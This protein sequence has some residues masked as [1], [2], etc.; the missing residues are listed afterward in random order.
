M[1][2]DS[3]TLLISLSR[4]LRPAISLPS[5]D[6]LEPIS[7]AL[8][9]FADSRHRVGPLLHIAMQNCADI[10]ADS[11]ASP[12]LESAYQK[13]IFASLRQKAAEKK[14]SELLAAHSVPFSFL[15]GRGLAEQLHDDPTARRS[16]DVDILIAP[17]STGQ[18][19]ALLNKEGYAFRSNTMRRTEMPEFARQRMELKRF[20]DITY[21]DPALS[22]PIELHQRLFRF[23]PK[24][25]TEDFNSSVQFH[26]NPSLSNSFYCLYLVLHGALAMWPRLKWVVD[27]S[28]IARTMPA[29]NRLEMLNIATGYGCDSAVAASLLMTER[30]FPDSLDAEWL[31]ILQPYQE[32]RDT[33][34]LETLFYQTLTA[35]ANGRPVLPWKS[36]MLSGSAD[37]IFPGK[38]GLMDCIRARVLNSVFARM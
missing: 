37:M 10:T 7:E 5:R 17:D 6:V 20:K 26:A 23:E 32:R 25:F 18:A 28:I 11:S 14:I 13:N 16:K 22:V 21:I 19:I 38:I 9:I 24:N 31:A 2:R 36:S 3:E 34:R 8:A 30:I 27:L 35:A 4:Y 29:H 15:K 1:D 33:N 12:I